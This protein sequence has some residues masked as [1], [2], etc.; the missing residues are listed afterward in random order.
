MAEIGKQFLSSRHEGTKPKGPAASPLRDA[1]ARRP[2]ADLQ[3]RPPAG[4]RGHESVPIDYSDTSL[5]RMICLRLEFGAWRRGGA[6][7]LEYGPS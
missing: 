2:P 4:L 7:E 6:G 5:D 1:A 3:W